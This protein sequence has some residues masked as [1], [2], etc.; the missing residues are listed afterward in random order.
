MSYLSVVETPSTSK[1]FE[2]PSISYQKLIDKDPDAIEKLSQSLG[3]LGAV[4]ISEVPGFSEE[5]TTFLKQAIQF[6]K[7]PPPE[8]NKV[9]S[10]GVETTYSYL[11]YDVDT[12]K[13]LGPDGK[14][15]ADLDKTSF[16]A[17]YP[18]SPYNKWP[19]ETDLQAAYLE[20]AKT[21]YE[22]GIR[23]L[24][25]LEGLVGPKE[26][27]KSF[28]GSHAVGRMIQYLPEQGE[29]HNPFWCGQHKDHSLFTGLIQAQYI[30]DGKLVDEPEGVGLHI[31]VEDVYKQ[32]STNSDNIIF[33]VGE[34][35]QLLLDDKVCATAHRVNKP[36]ARISNLERYTFALFFSPP[37]ETTVYS[38]SKL[39]QDKRYKE[40]MTFNDWHLATLAL[41]EEKK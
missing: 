41:H 32:V 10:G 19:Q 11:G 24:Y 27:I 25:S 13:F 20:L 3:K 37:I 40:G 14:W 21:I 1:N 34:F 6:F 8:K 12:E 31:Q 33:Q 26:K 2:L 30:Q 35:A 4:A 36:N 22:A 16:R 9:A 18:D 23:V 28:E 17:I 7:L 15:Y 5:R 38:N 29:N 39:A